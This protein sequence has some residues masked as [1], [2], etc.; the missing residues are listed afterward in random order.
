MRWHKWKALNNTTLIPVCISGLKLY[1]L[2][3]LHLLDTT[4]LPKYG[5]VFWPPRWLEL[6]MSKVLW[7]RYYSYCYGINF[8]G[9]TTHIT[10]SSK[11]IPNFRSVREI[12]I[13]FLLIL[14][15]G[16][17]LVL[18]CS[19]FLS[20]CF[21]TSWLAPIAVHVVWFWLSWNLSKVKSNHSMS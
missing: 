17:T 13:T 7:Y 8:P 1:S 3:I 15:K 21:Y 5:I 10:K 6:E 16:F 11:L 18:L 4:E 19:I 20:T 14:P 2:S 9:T 12:R